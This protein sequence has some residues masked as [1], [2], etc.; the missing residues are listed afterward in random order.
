MTGISFRSF[1]GLL[2]RVPPALLP[3]SAATFADSCEFGYGELREIKAAAFVKQLKNNA[4]SIYTENGLTF[5]SWPRDV[6]AARSPLANDQFDRLYYTDGN[7]FRVTSRSGMSITG[8]EPV[9]SYRV[10]VPRPTVAPTLAVSSASPLAEL[11]VTAM[12][13]Y[14]AK[15]VKYQ[16]QPIVLDVIAPLQ[17]WQFTPPTLNYTPPER[18][19]ETGQY[20]PPSPTETPSGALPVVRIVAK[21][22]DSVAL[23]LYSSNSAMVGT[24]SWALT[25]AKAASG[26]AYT[27]TLE[28]NNQQSQ[29]SRAYVYTLVNIYGEE[30]APSPPALITA[31]SGLNI[32]VSMALGSVIDYATI[33][34]IRV[35]RTPTGVESTDY[36]FVS[37]I[38]T[39]TQIGNDFQ[40]VDNVGAAAL[41]EP[42]SSQHNYPPSPLLRGLLALPNGIFMAYKGNELHFSDAYKPWSWPPAYVKTMEHAIVGAIVVGSGALITTVGQPASIAG[43][44]PDAMFASKLNIAQAGVSKW[45]IADLGGQVVYA[46]HDGLVLFD[47]GLPSMAFSEQFFTREV[48]RNLYSSGL[49]SM[50]FAVFD[51]QLIVYSSAMAF[52][53]FMIRLDEA[54]GAMT[55]L[56]ELRANCSFTSPL[57]DQCYFCNEQNLYQF[58]GGEAGAAR[59]RS[60]EVVMPAPINFGVAQA[61]CDGVW[62]IKFFA[63]GEL[64]HTQS[65]LSGNQT[66]RLPGGFR[67]DYWQVEISGKGRFLRLDIAQSPRELRRV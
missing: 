28:A 32:V 41:N 20:P 44:S 6:N 11:V 48:W 4:A 62:Q 50:R 54:R 7:D 46:S 17:K 66:F 21:K 31:G 56:S 16:E 5:Y 3:E 63:D 45:A 18:D 57:T 12:F 33:K 35:Y 19:P 10:G 60:R 55:E 25:L 38:P 51:G 26:T 34:E 27:L 64:R 1:A 42:L 13:H 15:G 30:G 53:P 67:A 40:F 39:L 23:D 61:V 43:G 65:N 9:S 49:D 37:T 58:A 36:F 24:G 29:Q 8:G 22:A 14:E 2:P 59:W 52:T 47:G